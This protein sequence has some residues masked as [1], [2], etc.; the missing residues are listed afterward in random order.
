[1]PA[2]LT[3]TIRAHGLS[4]AAPGDTVN[5][6]ALHVD[7]V[8]G[9][10]VVADGLAGRPAGEV[11]SAVAVDTV[12]A[13]IGTN[14]SSSLAVA[15][16]H[17]NDSV[18]R[19]AARHPR[20]ELMA[21]AVTA[22]RLHP[23]TGTGATVELAHA[24]DCRAYLQRDDQLRL[25]TQDHL[26]MRGRTRVITKVLGR[27]RVVEPDAAVLPTFPGDRWVLCTD[28]LTKVVA[29]DRI[30]ELLRDAP[31]P[32]VAAGGLLDAAR[33]AT[34]PDDVTVIVV[35]VARREANARSI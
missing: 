2:P 28:G 26:V 24:G 13:T 19:E 21:A 23:D 9:L 32:V 29:D 35:D 8:G 11:A 5:E 25:L 15:L 17:A 30:H 20:L 14:P 16:E 4:R 12:V 33:A 3:S 22:L 6:D 1:M 34:T 10:F 27:P 7:V 31:D 18:V